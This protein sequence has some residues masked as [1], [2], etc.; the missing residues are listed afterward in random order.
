MMHKNPNADETSAVRSLP[1]AAGSE[2]VCATCE[3]PNRVDCLFCSA[4]GQSLW[5]DCPSC[6]SRCAASEAFCS[7]CGVNR[8]EVIE[9]HV[10]DV[11][12][13]FEQARQLES[14]HRYAG[15][16]EVFRGLA[17]ATHPQLQQQNVL[18]REKI[19]SLREANDR[20]KSAAA[21]SVR[22]AEAM[23]QDY[24]YEE[25]IKLLEQTPAPFRT[26]GGNSLLD[27]ARNRHAEVSSLIDRI[28]EAAAQRRYLDLAPAVEE[29]LTLKPGHRQVEQL[30][31][32]LRDRFYR[33]AK[34]QLAEHRYDEAL[35]LLAKI[36]SI[37]RDDKVDQLAEQIGEL[38]WMLDDV[39]RAPVISPTVLEV[40]Q[41]LLK[42]VPDND[43]VVAIH[44]RLRQSA[45][46]PLTCRRFPFPTWA[47]RTAEP[48]LGCSV[49][50]LA[51]FRTLKATEE[52]VDATLRKYPGRF[53]VAAGLALQGLDQ[54]AL[55]LHLRPPEKQGVFGK[56]TVGQKKPPVTS[57]WGIDLG[58]CALK[59]IKLTRQP[60]TG[61]ITID[62][63][64]L[65][66]HATSRSPTDVTTDRSSIARET[67]TDFCRN[68]TLD[69]SDRICCNFPSQ[70]TL[71]RFLR[72][73][74]AD[75]KKLVE[76][77]RYEA[78]GAIPV[79]L[80]ELTWGHHLFPA[81]ADSATPGVA[82]TREQS[83]KVMLVAAKNTDVRER[84]RLFEES[85]LRV[86]IL[87]CDALALYIAASHDFLGSSGSS[88]ADPQPL[89]LL[90]VGTRA[91][92]LVI[93][94]EGEIWF[95]T[96]RFGGTDFTEAILR[97]FKLTYE[98]A[99]TLKRQPARAKR[100]SRLYG[101]LDSVLTR[102]TGELQRTLSAFEK[103]HPG[104]Q[105]AQLLAFGGGMQL[106]GLL[107]RLSQ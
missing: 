50:W 13:A 99:E 30:A 47:P 53:F 76:L 75:P 33:R 14:E 16:I 94:C 49:D 9:K 105:A 3:R 23:I 72:L 17:T 79:P 103:D 81:A 77:I 10:A 6:G 83:R 89:A 106:H 95:R 60:Q 38:T 84:L 51:G 67:L 40:G 2:I 92:N 58:D 59:A 61:E 22:T 73:P 25:A 104:Q 97:P 5:I 18:V 21:L 71:G 41:R 101:E 107:R 48:K 56:L 102:F 37:S 52:A 69:K 27:I 90:E 1:L 65:I 20:M 43:K 74:P 8:H 63:A 91:S 55:K 54:S 36:P 42:A 80:E 86:D 34:N 57:A 4:C 46:Q 82:A 39:R 44:A 24:A 100:L 29:L 35:A 88:P 68:V 78:T 96:L 26:P 66:E 62:A 28:R 12:A 87:Q 32:Q 7:V 98:Q 64:I 45:S 15:A 70:Q 19:Q 85:G 31:H 11:E 93:C